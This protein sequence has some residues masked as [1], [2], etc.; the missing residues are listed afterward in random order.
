[1]ARTKDRNDIASVRRLLVKLTQEEVAILRRY[2][3]PSRASKKPKTLKIVDL[4]LDPRGHNDDVIQ[5]RVSPEA[6]DNTFAILIADL[7]KKIQEVLI[8]DINLDR[9]GIYPQIKKVKYAC[10]KHL[11]TIDI[12]FKRGLTHEAFI[13]LDKV[14]AKAKSFELFDIAAEAL[15]TKS[16]ATVKRVGVKG[17]HE[18]F[19]ESNYY[20]KCHEVVMQA[21]IL[22]NQITAEASFHQYA[23]IVDRI[24][25]K[26]QA[27]QEQLTHYPSETAWYHLSVC[28]LFILQE[29]KNYLEA[30]HLL[31]E[32]LVRV[33]KSKAIRMAR[34]IGIAHMRL[35]DNALM[36]NDPQSAL[37][38]A[39]AATDYLDQGNFNNQ[40]AREFVF[41]SSIHLGK[42]E[43]LTNL[44]KGLINDTG[45]E[46]S[47]FYFAKRK[48]YHACLLVLRNRNKY[49]HIC[50][51]ECGA[52]DTDKDGWNI[53]LRI[54]NIMNQISW[55]GLYDSAESHIENLYQHINKTRKLSE[56]TPRQLAILDILK[57]LVRDGFDFE[58]VSKKK[59]KEIRLLS[60]GD[61]GY[62]WQMNSTEV[63][64]FDSWFKARSKQLA[65]RFD[66]TNLVPS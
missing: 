13:L 34:R 55:G 49:A 14:I 17:M 38:N 19:D 29:Q 8:M 30:D 40:L 1:M 15:Y 6:S 65:Y 61:K 37:D 31:N 7:K 58:L 35:A 41:I 27:I 18:L 51:Q 28:K 66:V 42:T 63:I 56:V 36:A 3:L 2:L 33:K 16:S 4:I 5:K 44:I 53:A 25:S 64:R 32:M 26:F 11:I 54:L 48:Y 9:K 46:K 60:S 22:Y 10:R 59:E 24:E 50:L 23:D 20:Q 45:K 43:H 52:L 57:A 47:P 12:F 39:E 21:Q 62:E